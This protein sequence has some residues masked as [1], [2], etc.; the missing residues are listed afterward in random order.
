M[1]K[2]TLK[3]TAA[4]VICCV[5]MVVV[6]IYT[7]KPTPEPTKGR[8]LQP[9]EKERAHLTS[10]REALKKVGEAKSAFRK[11]VRRNS[12]DGKVYLETANLNSLI[13]MHTKALEGLTEASEAVKRR[14]EELQRLNEEDAHLK[15]LIETNVKANTKLIAAL[16]EVSAEVKA[17][18]ELLQRFTEENAHRPLGPFMD[19]I[20]YRETYDEMLTTLENASNAYHEAHSASFEYLEAMIDARRW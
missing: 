18:T 8:S 10:A 3:A 4:I 14:N 9:L 19:L 11:A 17:L 6:V 12:E 13:E 1:N 7:P 5:L 2:Q 20:K 15:S 16:A